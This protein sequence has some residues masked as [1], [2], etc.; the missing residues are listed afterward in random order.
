MKL[1]TDGWFYF[2]KGFIYANKPLGIHE[3][4]YNKSLIEQRNRGREERE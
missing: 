2:Y 1:K 4:I 3:R